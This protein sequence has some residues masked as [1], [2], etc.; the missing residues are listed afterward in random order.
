MKTGQDKGVQARPVNSE[1]VTRKEAL[2]EQNLFVQIFLSINSPS[3]I[4]RLLLFSCCRMDISHTVVLSLA[5]QKKKVKSSHTYCFSE[6]LAQ[7]NNNNNAKYAY[8]LS[9]SSIFC[10]LS[11]HYSANEVWLVS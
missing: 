3:P 11:I 4:I 2:L 8:F 9:G 6:P 7:N 5:F 10:H 1:K